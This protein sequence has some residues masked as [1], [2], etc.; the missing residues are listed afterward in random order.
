MVIERPALGWALRLIVA[1]RTQSSRF[2]GASDNENSILYA[3]CSSIVIYRPTCR[4]A[5][6][7]TYGKPTKSAALAF[8]GVISRAAILALSSCN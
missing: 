3:Y 7:L 4:P 8:N 5:R 2:Y 6:P 1:L